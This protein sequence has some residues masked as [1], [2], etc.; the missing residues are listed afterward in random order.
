MRGY[1]PTQ[2]NFRYASKASARKMSAINLGSQLGNNNSLSMPD[3]KIYE[4][5]SGRVMIKDAEFLPA[6][7][8]QV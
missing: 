4:D 5:A 1:R 6:T 7:D 2:P 8:T 3:H